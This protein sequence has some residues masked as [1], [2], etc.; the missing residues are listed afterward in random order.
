MSMLEGYKKI[1]LVTTAQHLHLL[2]EIAD[3]L[4]KNGKEILME[5]GAG[6]IKGTSIG[7]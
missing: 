4:E 1:G 5:E 6:T 2:D 7:L 3:F